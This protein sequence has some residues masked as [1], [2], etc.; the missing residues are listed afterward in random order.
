[1]HIGQA[2]QRRRTKTAGTGRPGA[3]SLWAAA[4]CSSLASTASAA[5]AQDALSPAGVQA[6]HIFSLWTLTL[7]V[8]SLVFAAV[9]IA[10]L[11]AMTRAPRASRDARADLGP[12]EHPERRVSRVVGGAS[13]VSVLLLFGLL[14][15]DIA[16]DRALSRLPVANAVQLE[17]TGHQWWWEARYTD[18]TPGSG[19]AVANELHVPVGRP[20]VISLKADDVIHTFWVPNL[21]GKKDMIPG[22][23]ST[24]EFRADRA[25][26]YRGQCAEFCGLEHALMAFTVVAEPAAEYDAWL[27]RQRAPAPQPANALQARGEHLFTTGNCAGCHTVRGTSAQGVLGPDLTHVM[28]RPMLGAGTF[29]NTRANLESW[30]KAPGSMK[31]GTTMPP[32]QLSAQDLNALVA[33]IGTLQ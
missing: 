25:G 32:S 13:I 24:I 26:T 7:T 20:V 21:H 9:L 5:P 12:L 28:S 17:M 19:F 11:I 31:P 16:T 10:L 33:W 8:C 2:P 1:M 15:A 18:D 3:R 29:A 22:R 27:A 4:C 23:E 6:S 14:V 30:I